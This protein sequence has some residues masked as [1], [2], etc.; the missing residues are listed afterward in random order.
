MALG[1]LVH[2]TVTM[3]E[4]VEVTGTPT[5]TLANGGTATY[6]SGTGTN[7]LIFSYTPGAGQDTGDL[8]TAALSALTGTIKDL[9]GN[10]V[11]ATGFDDVNPVGTLAVDVVAP[12]VSSIVYGTNDGKLALSINIQF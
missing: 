3:S 7:T 6:A 10:D 5:I 4:V 9:S 11:V 8:K 2:L 1:E 12:I